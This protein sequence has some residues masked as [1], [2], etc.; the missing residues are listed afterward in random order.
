[1]NKR[2][3]KRRAAQLL[4]DRARSEVVIA[5]RGFDAADARRMIDAMNELATE[6]DRRGAGDPG[7][8]HPDDPDQLPL[9]RNPCCDDTGYADYA[10]T[11]CPNP[12]CTAVLRRLV[13]AGQPISVE[14]R[15]L[16]DNEKV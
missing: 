13:E 9:M 3:A 2:E 10:S 7:S 6:L 12:K 14:A 16:I 5:F 11:P 1:M 4:A 8:T 15:S